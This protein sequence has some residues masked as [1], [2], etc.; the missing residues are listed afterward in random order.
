MKVIIVTAFSPRFNHIPS[1]RTEKLAKYL[2]REVKTTI[3]GGMPDISENS[4]YFNKSADFGSAKLIEIKGRPFS[5]K[6]NVNTENSGKTIRKEKLI[7]KIKLNVGPFVELLIPISSGGAILYKMSDFINAINEEIEKSPHDEIILFTTYNPWFIIK[8]GYKVAKK[9]D[10]TWVVDFRDPPFNS[11]HQKTTYLPYFKR[12]TSRS[13]HKADLI[14]TVNKEIADS[15]KKLCKDDKKYL[16]L[17]NGFDPEDLKKINELE[18]VCN[19]IQKKSMD[20][21]WI[22]YTGRFYPGSGGDLE[23][24]AEVISLLKKRKSS[25]YS[26]IKFVYAG[27]QSE[28]VRDVFDKFEINDKLLDYGHVSHDISLLLQS[29]ADLLLLISY[30]NKT[31]PSRGSGIITGKVFEYFMHSK[32]ILVIGSNRWELKDELL[33]DDRSAIF[34]ANQKDEM[35][36]Y[37]THLINYPVSKD[38]EY[39]DKLKRVRNAYSYEALSQK[40]LK[41]LRELPSNK[42]NLF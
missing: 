6:F 21:F 31:N 30:T 36:D 39:N 28:Y 29:Q 38:K 35:I 12:I 34:L 27:N 10:I 37:I 25:E 3:I 2:S 42:K 1:R 5:K 24:F 18:G 15:F 13:L 33:E 16:V 7:K 26:R 4:T 19:K 11:P 9:N 20:D 41:K 22:V 32:P 17:T 8:V 14:T 40:L 23:P